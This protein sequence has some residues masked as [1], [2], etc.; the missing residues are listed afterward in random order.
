[1]R[2][3]EAAIAAACVAIG[4]LA[5]SL[6]TE[7]PAT[8]RTIVLNEVELNPNGYDRDAEWVEILNVGAEAVDLA[9]WTLSYNYPSDG[10]AA[11]A[12][13]SSILRPGQR[14]VYRY[15]ALRLRN[16]ANTVIRLHDAAG[17][18]VDETSALRDVYDDGKTWQRIP[19]GGDPLLPI[20]LL[21]D[22]T[23]NAPNK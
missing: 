11:I 14:I 8:P 23:K 6:A 15:E 7:A 13:A 17:A 20:W 3:R 10:A 22:G 16:D 9:G 18:F 1:M 2:I 5:A 4:T 21:R 12:V 19:D